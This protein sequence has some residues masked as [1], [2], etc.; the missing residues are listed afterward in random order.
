LGDAR[1]G[2]K[3][4][5]AFSAYGYPIQTTQAELLYLLCRAIGAKR[6]A[7]CAT[8]YGVSTLYLAAAV[9]DN[10]GGHVIGS[11]LVPE[12]A[13]GAH[14]ALAKAQLAHLVEIRVGDA[15]RSFRDLGGPIDL[16]LVDGWPSGQVPT[17]ALSVLQLV[18]P[19]L[20]PGALVLNDNGEDDYLAY[21]RD[22]AN[23]F[24]SMSLP[25]KGGME[26]SVRVGV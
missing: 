5:F 22:P 18:A 24:I 16:L 4:P 6:V 2:P 9:R 1:T 3:D 25:L 11:E 8:S 13:D 17:L 23:G 20:R 10:G 26:L 12:K 21:V 14:Q 7:E 19:Q 15:L